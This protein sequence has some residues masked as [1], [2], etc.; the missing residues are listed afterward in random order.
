M[1]RSFGAF[2]PTS[3][4]SRTPAA[5]T[6]ISVS[7]SDVVKRTRAFGLSRY[8]AP[9]SPVEEA[10]EGRCRLGVAPGAQRSLEDPELRDDDQAEDGEGA[11]AARCSAR[12]TAARPVHDG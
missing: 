4:S 5:L 3:S 1:R 12:V 10:L 2:G 6:W 11:R 7:N 9:A 8:P